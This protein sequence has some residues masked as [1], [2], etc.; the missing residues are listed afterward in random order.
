MLENKINLK[1]S[2]LNMA[3]SLSII[4]STADYAF[5]QIEGN[6]QSTA[7]YAVGS[8][9]SRMNG[10]ETIGTLHD[11]ASD[12]SNLGTQ[13][14]LDPSIWVRAHGGDIKSGN[15]RA[16]Y[17]AQAGFLQLGGDVFKSQSAS[18]ERTF[19]GVMLTVGQVSA[20]ID[21]HLQPNISGHKTKSSSVNMNNYGFGA[22]YTYFDASGAYLD[23]VAQYTIYD[24]SYGSKY[25]SEVSQNGNG[26]VVSAEVGKAFKYSNGWFVEPQVQLMYQFS[27]MDPTNGGTD[28]VSVSDDNSGLARAG[29]RVGY[30]SNASS[31]IHPYL[32]ADILSTIGHSAD[33]TVNNASANQ[34]YPSQWGAIGA[35]FSG[36]VARSAIVY[37]GMKYQHDFEGDM[38]GLGLNM[39]IQVNF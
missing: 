35:G 27:Q 10:F 18:G 23:T 25:N 9:L 34:G 24:T 14:D 13:S 36:D 4:T 1:K 17:N 29:V 30:D 7:G 3:I 2:I 15:S 5:A 20:D 31:T 37:A 22:Y 28:K 21:D 26:M 12:H 11:R 19:T 8:H 38:H 16:H 6:T 39:G 32:T 33:V